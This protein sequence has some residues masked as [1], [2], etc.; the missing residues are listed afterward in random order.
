MVSRLQNPATH[1]IKSILML[2]TGYE[3]IC[4]PDVSQTFQL[5]SGI[6][7]DTLRITDGVSRGICLA[8]GSLHGA[9]SFITKEG[10]AALDGL[11]RLCL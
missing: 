11:I 9:R 3:E 8:R 1:V 7:I 4:V 10:R 6:R 5:V 2:V